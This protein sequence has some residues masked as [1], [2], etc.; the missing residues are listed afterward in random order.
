MEVGRVDLVCSMKPYALVVVLQVGAEESKIQ[1]G[2]SSRGALAPKLSFLLYDNPCILN[3]VI[4][5]VTAEIAG[6]PLNQ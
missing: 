4:S 6:I 3:T 2:G 1:D 5:S